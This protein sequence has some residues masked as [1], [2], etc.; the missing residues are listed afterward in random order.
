M[1]KTAAFEAGLADGVKQAA[2]RDMPSFLS[3][4]RPESVK[5]IYRALKKDHPE[6]PAAMKARIAARQGRPGK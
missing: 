1:E 3:Q 5:K 2:K 4:D 6:M